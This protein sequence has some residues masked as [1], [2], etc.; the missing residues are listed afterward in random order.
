MSD[1]TV[2]AFEAS[3]IEDLRE[4]V[5]GN[6]Y[7]RCEFKNCRLEYKGGELPHFTECRFENCV[8]SVADA[9]GRTLRFLRRQWHSDDQ[10]GREM[11]RSAVHFVTGVDVADCRQ[12]SS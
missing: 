8:W 11:V 2:R 3:L 4:T 12:S 6:T 5:D 10:R 1:D 7:I 9:A